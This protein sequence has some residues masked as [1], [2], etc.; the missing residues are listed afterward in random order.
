M[1]CHNWLCIYQKDSICMLDKI[2]IDYNGC[3]EECIYPCLPED[4]LNTEKEKARK[5]YEYEDGILQMSN[6]RQ[7]MF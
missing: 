5:R 6:N 2:E 4:I 7:K 3:C 1:I